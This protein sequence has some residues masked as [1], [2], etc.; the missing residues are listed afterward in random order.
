MDVMAKKVTETK[1]ESNKMGRTLKPIDWDRVDHL[2]R[3]GCDGTQI[4]PFFNMHPNTF[5]DR[6]VEQYGM[7]FTEYQTIK[8][9]EG[10]ATILT[11]QYDKASSGDNTMM[12]WLGKNRLKQR[13]NPT[14]LTVSNET[15]QSFK[16]IMDQVSKAQEALKIEETN[17]IKE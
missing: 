5:Y 4:C 1:V 7:S 9:A 11:A 3:A 17:S 8:R 2:L 16:C 12:V 15:V 14:E 6:V 13:E 10:D